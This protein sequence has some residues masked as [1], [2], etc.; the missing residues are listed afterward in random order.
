MEQGGLLQPSAVG[1]QQGSALG[2]E[3]GGGGGAAEPWVGCSGCSVPGDPALGVWVWVSKVPGPKKVPG[4]TPFPCLGVGLGSHSTAD[5]RAGDR[6]LLP[7]GRQDKHSTPRPPRIASS[8]AGIETPQPPVR[9]LRLQS[10]TPCSCFP[11]CLPPVLLAGGARSCHHPGGGIQA[12]A[13]LTPGPQSITT[14]AASPITAASTEPRNAAAPFRAKE[15]VISFKPV[16]SF[17]SL[18]VFCQGR[19]SQHRHSG[20]RGQQLGGCGAAGP[21]AAARC[22]TKNLPAW[23]G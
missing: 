22:T 6:W 8:P 11:F 23:R 9:D 2:G 20:C 1:A 13:G 14:A 18:G 12:P 15:G 7:R 5:P 4:P 21:R 16:I 17:H 19:V 3:A 10:P